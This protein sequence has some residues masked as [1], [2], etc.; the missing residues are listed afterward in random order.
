MHS[1]SLE[2]F[3]GQPESYEVAIV[4]GQEILIGRLKDS[5]VGINLVLPFPDVSGKHAIIS[6]ATAVNT[7]DHCPFQLVWTICDQ[8]STNGTQLN[9]QN[10]HPGRNYGL[11]E[12]DRI[13][14]AGVQEILVTAC[15]TTDYVDG[16]SQEINRYLDSLER[17][18]KVPT[19]DTLLTESGSEIEQN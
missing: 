16:L 14:I 12:G 8:A 5:G 2:V 18:S 1:C 17:A 19:K 13:T 4:E 6:L 9:G 15:S 11:R 10:L 3:P 7:Y